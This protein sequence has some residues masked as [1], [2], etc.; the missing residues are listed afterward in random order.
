MNETPSQFPQEPS[1]NGSLKLEHEA[2][3]SIAVLAAGEEV[4]VPF[5]AFWGTAKGR[6]GA[7]RSN[8]DFE[9]SPGW[10]SP[11]IEPPVEFRGTQV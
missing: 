2:R 5:L 9:R 3:K 1:G 11:T 10:E 8:A 6:G 7:C 4:G